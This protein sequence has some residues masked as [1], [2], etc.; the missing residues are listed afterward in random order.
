MAINLKIVCF[1]K[2]S[3]WINN[4]LSILLFFGLT[5]QCE[6]QEFTARSEA[7]LHDVLA[8]ADDLEGRHTIYIETD[9]QLG[10]PIHIAGHAVVGRRINNTGNVKSNNSSFYRVK[11]YCWQAQ[12]RWQKLEPVEMSSRCTL[13]ESTS[14]FPCISA[15]PSFD[16]P[17]LIGLAGSAS[18]KGLV[19]NVPQTKAKKMMAAIMYEEPDLPERSILTYV[20]YSTS[21]RWIS[22]HKETREYSDCTVWYTKPPKIK[23]D[24]SPKTYISETLRYLYQEMGFYYIGGDAKNGWSTHAD[25]LCD[26]CR[27]SLTVMK[28]E[29]D[30][31]EQR[32]QLREENQSMPYSIPA[33]EVVIKAES[34]CNNKPAV[35]NSYDKL[36]RVPESVG[37][38]RRLHT[39]TGGNLTQGAESMMHLPSLAGMESRP[40]PD[41]PRQPLTTPEGNQG[42]STNKKLSVSGAQLSSP[43][44]SDKPSVPRH[45]PVFTGRH[46]SLDRGISVGNFSTAISP[47]SRSFRPLFQPNNHMRQMSDGELFYRSPSKTER[48][49]MRSRKHI[50]NEEELKRHSSGYGG[51]NG[52]LVSEV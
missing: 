10:A 15:L 21:S 19:I 3:R 24:E 50:N 25:E 9:L 32:M 20:Y 49:V 34:W 4:A 11:A 17:M 52:L 33:Y 6:A 30:Q 43:F 41:L 29:L 5:I 2:I 46:H 51:S 47:P 42:S 36:Q 35:N 45:L 16:A 26:L 14:S 18:L 48:P 37:R 38:N 39:E 13:N 12:G 31:L 27:N 8:Q 23:K 44:V 1:S 28:K 22:S 7:E 40:L